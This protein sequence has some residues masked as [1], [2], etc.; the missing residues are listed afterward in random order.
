MP[1]DSKWTRHMI[2]GGHSHGGSG[3]IHAMHIGGGEDRGG[4]TR[5]TLMERPSLASKQKV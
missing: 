2:G 4:S 5:A 1:D 3:W